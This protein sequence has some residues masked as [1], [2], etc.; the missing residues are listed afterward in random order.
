MC[1]SPRSNRLCA[2]WSRPPCYVVLQGFA[3]TFTT[4]VSSRKGLSSYKKKN[5]AKLPKLYQVRGR[6]DVQYS[7]KAQR[8][9]IQGKKN[10]LVQCFSIFTSSLY[11][12]TN[13]PIINGRVSISFL[14]PT[15]KDHCG[16]TWCCELCQI[17]KITRGNFRRCSIDVWLDVL[18]EM[19]RILWRWNNRCKWKQWAL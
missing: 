7:G 14:V 9:Q 13:I 11:F 2:S 5:D 8:A 4:V 3:F 18:T 19:W 6:A 17:F 12:L 10:I 1:W 16:T 15:K